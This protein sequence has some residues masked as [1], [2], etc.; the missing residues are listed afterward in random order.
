[1]SDTARLTARKGV[2]EAPLVGNG[3]YRLDAAGGGRGLLQVPP[4]PPGGALR[5]LVALHGAGGTPEGAVRPLL[6]AAAEAGIVLLA[7]GAR[8]ATWDAIRGGFG[9]D[10]ALVDDL[11]A[12]AL[13]LLPVAAVAVG[14]FSDGASYALGLG[15][16]NGDLL[17]AIVAFSPGF[18]PE[19][20]RR[21]APDV[22]ISHGTADAVL[23]IA[24]TSRRI[25][26][27]LQAEGR[28]VRYRE[29]AGPHEVPPS[30]AADAMRWLAALPP[31]APSQ[32]AADPSR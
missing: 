5:L 29:F 23:P 31:S 8:G 21:G 3:L 1:M 24:L 15:L 9:P 30:I 10:L 2:V 14:G 12:Q 17:R 11:L 20:P 19:A 22:F 26:P 18:I 13:A 27:R 32:V 28:A 25:V 6:T 4:P 16:A 7:P